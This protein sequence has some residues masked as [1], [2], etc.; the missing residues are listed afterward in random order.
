MFRVKIVLLSILLSGSI[1]VGA[2]LYFLSVM[3]KVSLDRIDREILAL[4][5]GQLNAL[6]PRQHLQNFDQALKFIYGEEQSKVLIVRIKNPWND[7]IFQSDHWPEEISDAAFTEF[8]R[9]M[10]DAPIFRQDT[11]RERTFPNEFQNRPSGPAPGFDRTRSDAREVRVPIP[12]LP[13]NL[14]KDRRGP[15]LFRPEGGSPQYRELPLP[16]P[17]TQLFQQKA[18]IK[19]PFFKTIRTADGSWRVGIMGS[20]RLTILLGMN[21]AGYYRDMEYFRTALQ[22]TVP[23][24]LLLLAGG[25]WIIAH[26]A[27]RPVALITRTAEGINARALDQRI[28]RTD[29]DRELSRLVEVINGMLDRLQKSFGQA[30]RFSADAA[31]ELQ[32]PLTILQ[33]ELDDAVQ[34]A[35]IGSEEQQR[36]SALLEEVQRLKSIVQKLLVLAR[37]DAGKLNLRMAP[38]DFSALIENAVEDAEVIAPHLRLEKQIEPKMMVKADPDLLGQVIQNLMSNAMKYNIEKGLIRLR[39]ATVGMNARFT[40]ANTGNAIPL[41]DREKIFDRF[42]RVDKSR[43][44]AIPGSGLGL[45]LSREIALAHGGDLRLDPGMDGLVSFTLSLPCCSER[46]IP[47]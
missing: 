44:R 43:N 15:P 42:Y 13:P 5:G 46:N 18:R 40:I 35:V 31:H 45:S 39:L 33:G 32:T 1:L 26:R 8:D 11:G 34:H 2:G 16:T 27:M 14:G 30:V 25:G 41:D 20:Q 38:V 7:V 3:D 21:M 22:I 10:D 23:I 24:A 6:V 9:T 17:D 47:S 28:P 19:K 12:G 4:G 36:Y 37:A 29:S